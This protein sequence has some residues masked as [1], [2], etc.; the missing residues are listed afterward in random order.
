MGRGTNIGSGLFSVSKKHY[1][2]E[3]KRNIIVLEEQYKIKTEEV[4]DN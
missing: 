3:T 2:P 1:L 4:T